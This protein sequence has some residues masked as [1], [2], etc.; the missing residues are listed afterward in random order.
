MSPS[1]TRRAHAMTA[2]ALLTGAVLGTAATAPAAAT[3]SAAWRQAGH[4]HTTGACRK[5]GREGVEAHKW[6]E[7]KCRPGHSGTYITLWVRGRG[8]AR[9]T[10][11]AQAAAP[12]AQRSGT[13]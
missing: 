7:Y 4:F 6:N 1:R 9:T 12:A 10:A 3:Q 8:G 11:P 2:L 13:G 5:A